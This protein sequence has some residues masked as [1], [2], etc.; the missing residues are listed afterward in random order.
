MCHAI[1]QLPFDVLFGVFRSYG[2]PLKRKLSGQ[3]RMRCF[4]VDFSTS[5]APVCELGH[6]PRKG[7][8]F[9]SLRT[10]FALLNHSL[11]V[12]FSAYKEKTGVTM[13]VTPVL[14]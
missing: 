4:P 5:S 1:C 11:R 14:R 3:R 7:K 2:F 12:W 9:L 10:A 6:L 13:M 8:A